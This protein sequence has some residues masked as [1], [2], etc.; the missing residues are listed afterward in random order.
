MS[1]HAAAKQMAGLEGEFWDVGCN[2]GGS[3]AIMKLAAPRKHIRLF[4]SF[5]GL[6]ESTLQDGRPS[7]P[8]RFTA[9]YEEELW[10]LGT[11]YSGWIPYSFAGLEQSKIAL[12]HIDLDLY[13]GTKD[14][15]AFV[16][17]RLVPGGMIV[18]DDYGSAWSGVTKAVDEFPK[19]GFS[20]YERAPEQIILERL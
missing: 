14:A 18:V 7:E 12:A 13:Q 3:A 10:I 6:P 11:V 16:Y 2:S 5:Q 1:L 17:P 4:D 20:V 19:H 15:L 9:K 8:T